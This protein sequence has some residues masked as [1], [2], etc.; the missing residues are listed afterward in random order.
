[1][2]KALD[3]RY[4]EIME[5]EKLFVKRAV[6]FIHAYTPKPWWHV[7]IPFRFLLEYY[8]RK[9]DIRSFQKSHLYLKQIALAMAYQ[10][11]KT[12]T[13]GGSDSEMLAQVRDYSMRLQQL[14]SA[15]L[16]QYIEQWMNLLKAHYYRL[17]LVQEK[18]YYL[19]LNKAYAGRQEYEDFL[20]KLADVEKK[21]DQIILD[22]HKNTDK[23]KQYIKSRQKAFAEIRER[24]LRE[25]FG[26][27]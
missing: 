8:S 20:S 9:K 23:S 1:M 13:A 25:A 14:H 4:N 24:E 15:D 2:N 17:L 10:D 16:H 22:T 18:Y 7:L 27:K 26:E 6:Y 5:Q 12:G 11:I 19:L 21:M 3:K